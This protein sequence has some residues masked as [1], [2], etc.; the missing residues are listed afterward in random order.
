MAEIDYND[1]YNNIKMELREEVDASSVASHDSYVVEES[2]EHPED[3][4]K[5]REEH[6]EEINQK[7][8]KDSQ[9]IVL[10]RTILVLSMLSMGAALSVLT[11]HVLDSGFTEDA[12]DA[13]SALF[14]LIL[15]MV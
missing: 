6:L 7:V 10:F 13:V 14:Q 5:K 15:A 11:Y 4:A 3:K 12:E 8:K 1:L 2:N 9:R